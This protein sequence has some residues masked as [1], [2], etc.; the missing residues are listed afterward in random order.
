MGI[1]IEKGKEEGAPGGKVWAGGRVDSACRNYFCQIR[2]MMSNHFKYFL[3]CY[4]NNIAEVLQSN[5]LTFLKVTWFN[6]NLEH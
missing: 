4:S 1:V 5:L 2:T 6:N 3:I